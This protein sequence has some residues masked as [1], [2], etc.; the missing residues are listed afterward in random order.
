MLLNLLSKTSNLLGL[1]NIKIILFYLFLAI[2]QL[3]CYFYFYNLVKFSWMLCGIFSFAYFN[4]EFLLFAILTIWLLNRNF[5]SVIVCVFLNCLFLINCS[6]QMLSF[7]YSNSFINADLIMQT[8]NANLLINTFSV[9]LVCIPIILFTL[10]MLYLKKNYKA[11]TTTQKVFSSLLLIFIILINLFGMY[12]NTGFSKWVLEKRISLNINNNTPI[13]SMY[14]V[15][16]RLL[17]SRDIEIKLTE[18]D[19]I[20][21]KDYGFIF[22]PEKEYPFIKKTFYKKKPSLNNNQK[23]KPNVIVF[24]TESLSA[25]KLGCYGSPH[26][27]ISPNIDRFAKQSLIIQSYYN[28]VSP[29][30]RGIIGQLCSSYPEFGYHTWKNYKLQPP[31]SYSLP[32]IFVEEGYNTMYFSACAPEA[33]YLEA[34]LKNIGFKKT[35]FNNTFGENFLNGEKG[36]LQ[37]SD[38]SDHQMMRGLIEFLKYNPAKAKPFLIGVSNI[39]TH[40]DLDV[41]QD[42]YKYSNTSSSVLNTSYNFDHAFGTFWNYFKKSKYYK[43]TIVILTAD[44]AHF[45]SIKFA[46][47][48]GEGFNKLYCD[49]IALIIYNPIKKLHGR[50]AAYSTSIDFAPSVIEMMDFKN[51]ETPFL[52]QSIFS[53]RKRYKGGIGIFR[54][55]LFLIKKD[56]VHSFS[57]HDNTNETVQS[58]YKTIKYSQNI[59]NSNRLWYKK[60]I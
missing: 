21:G 44:H 31:P 19:L 26:E 11:S 55:N 50:Y 49:E 42:G 41:S 58:L 46:Q 22:N 5:L 13:L 24:F 36:L 52:G 60:K 37:S 57:F 59:Q 51:R 39:E 3:S 33:T 8:S 43:N 6:L 38:Y 18:K 27:N 48:A 14:N 34:Q 10:F 25:L 45:P 40:V 32:M 12:A 53:N 9:S 2:F 30:V 16:D 23:Q 29:T 15:I 28:H 47:M 54:D 20:C 4:I 7:Y 17:F 35:Y 1:S 56:G